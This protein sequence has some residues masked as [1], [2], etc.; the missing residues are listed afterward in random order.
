M[1]EDVFDEFKLFSTFDSVE[2]DDESSTAYSRARS[3]SGS[4]SQLDALKQENVLLKKLLCKIGGNP[5][6]DKPFANVLFYKSSCSKQGD[7]EDF[8]CD[9]TRRS[10]QNNVKI[11]CNESGL[12]SS[13]KRNILNDGFAAALGQISDNTKLDD[14]D[15]SDLPISCVQYFASFCVDRFGSDMEKIFPKP[16]NYERVYFK[17]LP[18]ETGSKVSQ[19]RKKVCFNCDGDHRLN[20]CPKRRDLA[21]IS[22]KRREFMENKTFTNESRYHEDQ[23]KREQYQHIKPGVISSKLRE[24][25][26]V[27]EHDL[28]PFIYRMRM[29]GYP[30]G[31]VPSND[32]SGIVVY[33]AEGKE[34]ESNENNHEGHDKYVRYPGFNV[35]MPQG[36]IFFK[37]IKY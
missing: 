28:P 37:M 24:A 30:P 12:P 10:A 19:R 7:F 31:W 36:E 2:N 22:M 9:Q 3:E 4:V 17:T 32:D 5:S 18:E 14:K 29:I 1:D 16:P 8:I 20:D 33:G 11:V 6:E 21:R 34:E 13:G 25:L 27:S 15:L 35:P 23:T 26:N